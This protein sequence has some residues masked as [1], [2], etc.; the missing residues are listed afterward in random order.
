MTEFLSST[1]HGRS[2]LYEPPAAVE[3]QGA[4][5]DSP[6]ERL[7]LRYTTFEE[8]ATA[9][10][11]LPDEFIDK[12]I[13][14]ETD[15]GNSRPQMEIGG[16]KMSLKG[17]L[18]KVPTSSEEKA[19][20]DNPE[21]IASS[22]LAMTEMIYRNLK[23]RAKTGMAPERARELA[24]AKASY[25]QSL[26]EEAPA[27]ADKIV[28]WCEGRAIRPGKE[29]GYYGLEID[30]KDA[31]EAGDKAPDFHPNIKVQRQGG[32]NFIFGYSDARL[33]QRMRLS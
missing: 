2:E 18:D 25:L 29:F 10:R 26:K 9:K 24:A 15:T 28:D 11:P 12:I 19:I 6:A 33:A 7:R 13:A 5:T 27:A 23:I 20:I 1:D 4:E 21:A 8:A 31:L 16:D 22:Y 32:G 30:G 17:Y 14:V 3:F